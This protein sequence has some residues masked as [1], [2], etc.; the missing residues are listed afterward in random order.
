MKEKRPQFVR[1]TPCFED[2][3]PPR[4][5][6]CSNYRDCLTEAAFKNFCLDCSRCVAVEEAS[7]MPKFEINRPKVKTY[8]LHPGMYLP[9]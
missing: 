8:G 1:M 4:D 2:N 7:E 6:C 9:A 3:P 5:I